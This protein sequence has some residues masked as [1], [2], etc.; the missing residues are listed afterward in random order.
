[1][2]KCP[3]RKSLKVGN[4]LKIKGKYKKI[5]NSESSEKIKNIRIRKNKKILESEKIKNIR[6]RKNKKYQNPKNSGNQNKIIGKYENL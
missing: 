5:E 1:M 2:K 3:T 4:I 6:I